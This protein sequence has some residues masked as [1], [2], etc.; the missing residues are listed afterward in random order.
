LLDTYEFN[1]LIHRVKD[2]KE[3]I[4]KKH[5]FIKK[6]WIPERWGKVKN[7]EELFAFFGD[8]LEKDTGIALSKNKKLFRMFIKRLNRENLLPPTFVVLMS[9]LLLQKL[10]S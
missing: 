6:P 7:S 1:Q 4:D 3:K 9:F 10:L 5:T 2:L 8:A